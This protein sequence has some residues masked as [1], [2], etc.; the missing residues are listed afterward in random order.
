[1]MNSMR[2]HAPWLQL[3]LL[4]DFMT[5]QREADEVVLQARAD[6]RLLL[7]GWSVG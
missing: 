7:S 5:Q 4:L 6:I 2:L 3:P 1:M